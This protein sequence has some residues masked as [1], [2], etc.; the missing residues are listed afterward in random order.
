MLSLGSAARLPS[1]GALTLAVSATPN[2]VR[3]TILSRRDLMKIRRFIS[4]TAL[5]LARIAGSGNAF[6]Q[7]PQAPLHA[8]EPLATWGKPVETPNDSL[9][10]HEVSADGRVTFRLY[11][12]LE[13]DGSRQ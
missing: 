2:V 13:C 4:I 8:P 5:F 3:L 11:A 12:K 1:H 9:V 10:S 6:S 7:T